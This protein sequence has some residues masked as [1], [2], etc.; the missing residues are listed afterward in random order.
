MWKMLSDF[1]DKWGLTIVIIA[2]IGI[3]FC[4]GM[5]ILDGTFS[6]ALARKI[7]EL[8]VGELMLMLFAVGLITRK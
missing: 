6:A 1:M 5:A 3:M 2:C 7:T 4:T 8:T